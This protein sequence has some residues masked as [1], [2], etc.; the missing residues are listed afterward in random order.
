MPNNR[1]FFNH[2]T[3]IFEN[4][5]IVSCQHRYIYRQHSTD[6]RSV[7]FREEG[8]QEKKCIPSRKYIFTS[9][10]YP[11]GIKGLK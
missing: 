4:I 7:Y 5:I 1:L 3:Y 2:N 11:P 8:D 9:L 6:S 10:H